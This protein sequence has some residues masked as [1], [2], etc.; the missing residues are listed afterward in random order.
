MGRQLEGLGLPRNANTGPEP[1]EPLDSLTNPSGEVV[2]YWLKLCHLL[3]DICNHPLQSCCPSIITG[4]S[5]LVGFPQMATSALSSHG[6]EA[7]GD[8]E[9]TA[10]L[11]P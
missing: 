9:G 11:G 4:T 5:G 3:G 2:S 10:A 1:P 7:Q 8:P 6:D